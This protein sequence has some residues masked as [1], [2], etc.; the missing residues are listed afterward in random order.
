MKEQ[1]FQ[2]V[3][4]NKDLWCNGFTLNR[5][6]KVKSAVLTSDSI[7]ADLYRH[8]AHQISPAIMK[9]EK[10]QTFDHCIGNFTCNILYKMMELKIIK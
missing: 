1:W 9:G 3:I 2:Y 4:D 6:M 10:K 8:G 7:I 5:L